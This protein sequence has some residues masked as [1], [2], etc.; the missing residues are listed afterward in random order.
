MTGDAPIARSG[1]LYS[2]VTPV[3]LQSYRADLLPGLL[4]FFS[5][6]ICPLLGYQTRSFVHSQL[7]QPALLQLYQVS[8]CHG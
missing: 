1:V 5:P 7:Q 3:D 4:R 8:L 2:P 6:V